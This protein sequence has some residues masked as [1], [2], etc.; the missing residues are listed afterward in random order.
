MPILGQA[1]AFGRL[2]GEDA[3]GSLHHLD[4]YLSV[5]SQIDKHATSSGPKD[6]PEQP[7]EG[8]DEDGKSICFSHERTLYP[9]R[10]PS[11]PHRSAIA[12]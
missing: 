11:Q 8:G 5:C 12:R 2:G 3:H 6:S 4:P 7:D 10:I 9:Q 1:D